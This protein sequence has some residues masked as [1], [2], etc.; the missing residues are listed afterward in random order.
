MHIP[1]KFST[2]IGL[3][4]LAMIPLLAFSQG[5]IGNSKVVQSERQV[6]PFNRI[7]SNGS[8]EVRVHKSTG[9]RVVVSTDANLQ[10]LFEAEKADQYQ[11]DC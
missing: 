4:A 7:A 9:F 2:L 6:E 3:A 1:G 10:D 8:A 5:G 11:T